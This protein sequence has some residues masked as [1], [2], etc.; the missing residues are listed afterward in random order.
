MPSLIEAGEESDVIFS[1]YVIG[2][3]EYETRS[4]IDQD[5][6]HLEFDELL[7]RQT[8]LVDQSWKGVESD[9]IHIH[10]ST[11][12]CDIP[13]KFGTHQLVYAKETDGILY[14][15]VLMCN[16]TRPISECPRLNSSVARDMMY[17]D[18]RF[19]YGTNFIG[20]RLSVSEIYLLQEG[21]T[22]DEFTIDAIENKLPEVQIRELQLK[23]RE[24]E[25]V[26]QELKEEIVVMDSIE[27]S[28]IP[29]DS[30]QVVVE[31]VADPC[32]LNQNEYFHVVES[33]SRNY[34][35]FDFPNSGDIY[36]IMGDSIVTREKIFVSNDGLHDLQLIELDSDF[37]DRYSL[38]S[39]KVIVS[40]SYS[41]APSLRDIKRI[42]RN[43]VKK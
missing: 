32:Y 23:V 15:S 1:G 39:N 6:E 21:L 16:R 41:D 38:R 34:Y 30:L 8:L 22:R 4:T 13:M 2:L 37:V 40:V 11:Q 27:L 31:T 20:N 7:I 43:S 35:H 24:L 17:L 9:T 3:E 5:S 26:I 18:N 28:L 14:S 12:F 29:N 19:N 33:P 25:S 42:L 10:T 36:F